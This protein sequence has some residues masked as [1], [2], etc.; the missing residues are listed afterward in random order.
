MKRDEKGRFTE[1]T[2]SA[3]YKRVEYGGNSMGEQQRNFCIVLG[4]DKIPRGFVVHHLDGNKKNNDINNLALMTYSA[5]NRLHSH[6]PWN[7]GVTTKDNEKW[8][9][10]IQKAI[11]S[12]KKSYVAVKGKEVYELR[13]QGMTLRE[14]GEKLGIAKETAGKRLSTYLDAKKLIDPE[15]KRRIEKFQKI[16]ELRYSKALKWDEVGEI[17]GEKGSSVRR[18]YRRFLNINSN[19]V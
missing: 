16:K 6:K 14:V 19:N 10:T 18:F 15:Q 17:M 13:L 12:R 9:R 3:K 2:G 1:T 11:K 4:I 7:K 5:H 8:N